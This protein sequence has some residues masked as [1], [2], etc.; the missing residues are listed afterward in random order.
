MRRNVREVVGR[1]GAAP[2]QDGEPP[3]SSRGRRLPAVETVTTPPKTT[4]AKKNKEPAGKRKLTPMPRK[5]LVVPE[6]PPAPPAAAAAPSL[7]RDGLRERLQ[8]GALDRSTLEDPAVVHRLRTEAA[9]LKDVAF[10]GYMV[11]AAGLDGSLTSVGARLHLLQFRASAGSPED[12]VEQMLL[13]LLALARVRVGRLHAL[14][15]SSKTPELTRAYLGA[16]NRMTSEICKTVLTLI[17]YRGSGVV[18]G[19]QENHDTELA[20]NHTGGANV[21][22]TE[23]TAGGRRPSES[24]TPRAADRGR[25]ATP[26]RGRPSKPAVAEVDRPID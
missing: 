23:P 6:P 11:E 1:A 16:A 25:A 7:P 20:S 13:D 8:R 3:E 9:I 2:R 15:E 26:A 21:R 14:A 19:G 18:P 4:A 24:G 22:P 12:P 5:P 17:A 10:Q